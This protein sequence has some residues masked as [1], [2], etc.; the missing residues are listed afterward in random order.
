MPFCS[1][2][3]IGWGDD[4]RHLESIRS[5]ELDLRLFF[6]GYDAQC[7]GFPFFLTAETYQSKDIN[8]ESTRSLNGMTQVELQGGLLF[9]GHVG[10]NIAELFDFIL[11]WTTLDFM[12]DDR[13]AIRRKEERYA[14]ELSRRH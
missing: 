2:E 3:F 13:D 6:K 4:G 7:E 12:E 5:D 10:F 14:D 8:W 1:W 11:G 9:G